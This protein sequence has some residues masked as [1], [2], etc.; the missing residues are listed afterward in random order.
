VHLGRPDL[1]GIHDLGT[2]DYGDAVP[3]ADDEVPVFWACGVTPQAAIAQA[4]LPF[5]I[6]H[7]PGCMLVTDPLNSRLA[8]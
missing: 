2:P 8:A 5:A 3:V 1:I 7:A 6:T 4:K